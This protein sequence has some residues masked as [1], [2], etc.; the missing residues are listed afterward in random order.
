MDEPNASGSRAT[1]ETRS[2]AS[3]GEPDPSAVPGQPGAS[4]GEQP[5]EQDRSEID[6]RAAYEAELNRIASSDLILQTTVSLINIGGRRLGSTAPDEGPAESERDLEQVRDAIDGARALMPILERRM[7]GEL[8]PM[9]DAIAQLQMAYAREVQSASAAAPPA[10]AEPPTPQASSTSSKRRRLPAASPSR[11]PG[12]LRRVGGFGF[13]G[14]ERCC[15]LGSRLGRW[16]R[17]SCCALR[18]AYARACG[19]RC[20]GCR[21]LD[22]LPPPQ[23][24]DCARLYAG[25]CAR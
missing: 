12:P 4:A 13:P 5:S 3:G 14:T 18:G 16:E 17:V 9:R 24:I 2:G 25:W 21:P 1:T 15:A 19:A 8:G 7:P 11:L 6:R 23:T 20:P 22:R 10:P